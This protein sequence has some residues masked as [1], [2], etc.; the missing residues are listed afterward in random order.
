MAICFEKSRLSRY[1]NLDDKQKISLYPKKML[2][3]HDLYN[4]FQGTFYMFICCSFWWKASCLT[5][6]RENCMLFRHLYAPIIYHLKFL[7]IALISICTGSILWWLCF[8]CIWNSIVIIWV[9]ALGKYPSNHHNWEWM[10]CNNRGS[11][12]AAQLCGVGW[13]E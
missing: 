12:G 3:E 9:M 4:F 7:L 10:P 6:L 5:N 2:I 8:S 1:W 11:W 13:V